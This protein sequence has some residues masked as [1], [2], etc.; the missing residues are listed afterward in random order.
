[1]AFGPGRPI[2]RHR[3]VDPVEHLPPPARPSQL[4]R[5]L[6]QDDRRGAVPSRYRFG[7]NAGA[8][9]GSATPR[10]EQIAPD[11]QARCWV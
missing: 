7:Q 5:V 11:R 10:H 6:E 4:M 9:G 3:A 2:R 1:M 8:G